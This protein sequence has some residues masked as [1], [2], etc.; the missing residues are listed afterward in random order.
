MKKCQ[1]CGTVELF[2][3][4]ETYCP[5]DCT[6]PK[7]L[8]SPM[9]EV[10]WSPPGMEE[11]PQGLQPGNLSVVAGG[12]R[13][14]GYKAKRATMI[15]RALINGAP[16]FALLHEFRNMY[17]AINTITLRPLS[18][19]PRMRSLEIQL[20]LN[21]LPDQLPIG[22]RYHASK[23]TSVTESG[24]ILVYKDRLNPQIKVSQ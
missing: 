8:K 21:S 13:G 2:L 4:N 19:H 16:N 15:C 24:A 18:G 22:V 23:I 9:E 7:V 12:S 10:L 5:N 14:F 6:G 20:H 17:P 1:W 3:L 11:P